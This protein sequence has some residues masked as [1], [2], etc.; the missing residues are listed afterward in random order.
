MAAKIVSL[1]GDSPRFL[2]SVL[3]D[4]QGE[5]ADLVLAINVVRVALEAEEDNSAPVGLRGSRSSILRRWQA[6]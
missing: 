1:Q 5:I 3:N 4:Y 2:L 6:S